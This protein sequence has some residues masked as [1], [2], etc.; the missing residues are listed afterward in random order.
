[1]LLSLAL[2]TLSLPGCGSKNSDS[3]ATSG[4]TSVAPTT[5]SAAPAKGTGIKKAQATDT[6]TPGLAPGYNMGIGSKAK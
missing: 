3:D 4:G 5:S 2:A 6:G 1:M